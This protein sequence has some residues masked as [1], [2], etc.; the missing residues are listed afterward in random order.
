MVTHTQPTTVEVLYLP[1]RWVLA[2]YRSSEGDTW[3]ETRADFAANHSHLDALADD[4]RAHG[5]RTPLQLNPT[6]WVLRGHHRLL[7]ADAVDEPV[8]PVIYAHL[9]ET[10]R[11]NP[12]TRADEPDDGLDWDDDEPWQDRIFPVPAAA[13]QVAVPA[14]ADRPIRSG[15]NTPLHETAAQH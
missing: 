9:D 2:H 10:T 6:G 15:R 13:R 5:V 7:T 11:W 1:T 3:G 14:P 8:V 4:I 12:A